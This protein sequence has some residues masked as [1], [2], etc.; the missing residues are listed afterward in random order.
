[1]DKII[2]FVI[3]ALIVFLSFKADDLMDWAMNNTP[4]I[5]IGFLIFIGIFLFVMVIKDLISSYQQD[6]VKT[7]K[8]VIKNLKVLGFSLFVSLLILGVIILNVLEN[9]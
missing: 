8:Y 3:L 4:W 5:V 2:S 1:M 7:K 9:T 6:P